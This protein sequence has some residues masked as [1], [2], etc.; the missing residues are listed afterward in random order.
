MPTDGGMREILVAVDLYSRF[1]FVWPFKKSG[2]AESTIEALEQSKRAYLTPAELLI[3]NSSHF[4]NEEVTKWLADR[5]YIKTQ[6]APYV[7]NG[8]VE[9]ANKLLLDRLRKLTG[10]DLNLITDKKSLKDFRPRW[11]DQ[12]QD[13]VA[14]IN[15]RPIPW[16]G[17]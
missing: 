6:S 5:G 7:H 10:Q 2:S 3:D 8:P 4:D 14:R 9:A 11:K 17:A 15:D 16:L 1:V 12:L 13:A